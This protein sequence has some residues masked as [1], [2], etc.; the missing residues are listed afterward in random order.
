[1]KIKPKQYAVALYESLSGLPAGQAGLS[2]EKADVV[3]KNFVNF[4]AR[5]N[6]LRL[7]PQIINYFQKYANKK[8]GIVDL[9]I[10][11]ARKLKGETISQI[12]NILPE[13]LDKKIE[14]INVTEEVVESLIGGFSLL[15]DD[16]IF[17]FTIKNKLKILKN[18]LKNNLK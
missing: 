14:K 12:K 16:F 2:R 9:K 11:T 18:N 1:M 17:D 15:C 7:A 13:L 10:R 3:V 4:L 6:L 8:E 5:N